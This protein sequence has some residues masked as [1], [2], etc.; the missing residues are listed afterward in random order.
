MDDEFPTVLP[1][2]AEP[3]SAHPLAVALAARLDTREP[4]ARVLLLGFGSGRNL[5]PLRAASLCVT[6]VEDDPGR[7]RDAAARFAG[8]RTVR[9]INAG[10]AAPD[11]SEAPF[12]GALST[13][14]LL[15]GRPVDV[16]AT[17]GAVR[18]Y[19]KAGGL[20]FTTLGSVGDPRFGHGRRID[21]RTYAAETGAEV[22]VPH[23]FFD[24]A[25]VRE[26]FAGFVIE[27]MVEG[28]AAETAGR[29]AHAQAEA[30]SLVHWFVRAALPAPPH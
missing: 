30:T 14:A 24:R 4:G 9:V 1:Q 5:P 29:W 20:F 17:I 13:H 26:L 21:D 25:A 10:Y 27:S 28:S 22:G 8:D 12:A 7:A 6:V 11:V 15:H 16:A 2:P 19:L 3:P 18:G 23:A